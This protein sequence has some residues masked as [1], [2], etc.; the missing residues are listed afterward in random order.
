MFLKAWQKHNWGDSWLSSDKYQVYGGRYRYFVLAPLFAP[1]KYRHH[2]MHP[3]HAL[4]V[5]ANV[6]II[7]GGAMLSDDYDVTDE[8]PLTS[9]TDQE[10]TAKILRSVGAAMFLAV[11]VF[12]NACLYKS[13]ATQRSGGGP[14]HGTLA[15]LS[16]VGVFL[17]VRGTFG[18]LQSC[19]Y[20]VCIPHLLT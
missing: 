17:L 12:W 15:I 16:V 5:P 11:A 13:I 7:V 4:L 14:L 3:V 10:Q 6:M 2:L 9:V 19:L 8:Q 1:W 20:S 18:L